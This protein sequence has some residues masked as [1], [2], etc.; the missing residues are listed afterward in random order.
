M[1]WTAGVVA[2]AAIL[3]LVAFAYRY[4]SFTEFSNDH[5][6]HLL[7][8]LKLTHLQVAI[9]FPMTGF[10]KKKA[11]RG[12]LLM[13]IVRPLLRVLRDKYWPDVLVGCRLST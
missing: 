13:F 11:R 8:L 3:A 4:L 2:G 1:R 10:P 12:G 5:F 6:V 9:H 7:S